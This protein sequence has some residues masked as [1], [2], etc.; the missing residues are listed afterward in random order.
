MAEVLA[1]RVGSIDVAVISIAKR[2]RA[3]AKRFLKEIEVKETIESH[4]LY[5]A[6]IETI[7]G[8]VR[9]LDNKHESAIF[10]GHNPGFTYVYNHFDD[11]GIY[12]LPTC[13]IFE[14]QSE[15]ETWSSLSPSNSKTGLLLYP[16]L[17]V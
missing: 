14:I 2:A 5:H 17:F 9:G 10:F 3:T 16:K 8:L 6:W 4:E 11:E 12:N 1:E 15:S 13:G 7:L